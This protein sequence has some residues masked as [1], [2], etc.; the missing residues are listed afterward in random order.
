MNLPGPTGSREY[1][2]GVKTRRAEGGALILFSLYALGRGYG[3]RP[4][5]SADM[6]AEKAVQEDG[7]DEE[8]HHDVGPVALQGEG[9]DGKQN[10]GHRR[11]DEQQQPELD[12]GPVVALPGVPDDPQGLAKVVGPF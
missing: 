8:G 11:G 9:G 7:E 5:G 2:W 4:A 10:P 6:S 1:Q 3:K 12:D